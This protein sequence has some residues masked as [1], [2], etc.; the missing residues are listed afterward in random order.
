[1]GWPLC[2][3]CKKPLLG[4]MDVRTLRDSL[5]FSTWPQFAKRLDMNVVTALIV[6]T[7]GLIAL[8]GNGSTLLFPVADTLKPLAFCGAL[9]AVARYYEG[10][11]VPSFVLCLKSLIAMITFSSVFAMLTY[12]VGDQT[13][14]GWADD[15]LV[16]IDAAFGLSAEGVVT[17]TNQHATVGLILYLAYVSVIPQTFLTIAYHGLTNDEKRLSLFIVRFIICALITLVGFYFFPAKGNIVNG[18]PDHYTHILEHLESLRDGTRTLVTW[19]DAEG[20]ITFPSFHTIWGVLVIAAFHRTVLFWPVL[21]LNVVMIASTVP[22]GLHYFVDVAGGLFISGIVIFATNNNEQDH[23]SSTIRPQS[24]PRPSP[25]VYRPTVHRAPDACRR[26]GLP[27]SLL[28]RGSNRGG[29]DARRARRL[30]RRRDTS[31]L[32]AVVLSD[33]LRTNQRAS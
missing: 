5:L 13:P 12:C 26:P 8:V 7:L 15:L 3:H 11:E 24:S 20:L 1:M 29:L 28:R 31:D 14:Y 6:A 10:R 25:Q 21:V 23:L 18:V 32:L 9:F 17:W 22:I 2:E 16:S 30:S 27:D 4:C 33:H 19:R